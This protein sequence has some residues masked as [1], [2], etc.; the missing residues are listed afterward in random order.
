MLKPTLAASTTAKLG[1]QRS[2]FR[3][4]PAVDSRTFRIRFLTKP[5]TPFVKMLHRV[6]LL[7]FKALRLASPVPNGTYKGFIE[8]SALTAIAQH[9]N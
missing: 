7:A 5:A 6:A 4:K 1:K 3:E 2:W 8:P 9:Q